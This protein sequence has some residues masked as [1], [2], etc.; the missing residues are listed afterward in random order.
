M[1]EPPASAPLAP[2]R[3]KPRRR[4]RRVTIRAR[5][6]LGSLLI[7][8]LIAVPAALLIDAQLQHIVR[9][10]TADGLAG[11][12][13]EYVDDI[14]SGETSLDKPPVWQWVAV[15]RPD[16]STA[17]SSLPKPLRGRLPD[18]VHDDADDVT[19]DGGVRET[20]VRG[21]GYV[22]LALTA[23]GTG[24][25]WTVIAADDTSSEDAELGPMR[26]L[27]L[28]IVVVLVA[29]VGATGWLLTRFSLR[30][31]QDLQ[32]TAERLSVGRSGE[33]LPVGAVDDEISRLAR[34]LNRL[35]ERMRAAANRERQLVS[36]A[37]H[38]LRT[39]VAV[40]R[41]RL[42]LAAAGDADAATLRRDLEA[43]QRDAERLSTL[44]T[45]L[46]ELSTIEARGEQ[47]RGAGRATVGDLQDEVAAA[48]DRAGFRASSVEVDV[49]L[50]S[51]VDHAVSAR[52]TVALAAEDAGR[53]VDNLVGNAIR[54]L[55]E[56][57][58]PEAGAV[59]VETH[60]ILVAL[61]IGAT[62]AELRVADE[63]GG[64]PPE[65]E[66]SALQRFTR[67]PRARTGT[68]AGLGL[69]IV[70]ALVAAAS[71]ELRLDNRR[72]EGLTVVVS[73][74]LTAPE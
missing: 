25:T 55:E 43:A 37:S 62:S 11:D 54:A 34:T 29:G 66:R 13:G 12:A 2:P 73:L 63:A 31:V 28:A 71:G 21:T 18:L 7:A 74:P 68:G 30:P 50:D 41:T 14:E 5:I 35:I 22:T 45:S 9:L 59:P 8:V 3:L 38:E 16:G 42:E 64:L 49:A 40:L 36:D 39:P 60:R 15:V 53:I 24:G 58:A 33:L 57:A 65:L 72:G 48:V 56:R 1:S 51:A 20:Q 17:I 61:S 47:P 32:Q 19:R 4:R 23:D 27:L 69:P 52:A 6:A 46:L 70:A 26:L 67:G 10:G 44:V